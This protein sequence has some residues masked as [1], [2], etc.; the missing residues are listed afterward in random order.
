MHMLKQCVPDPL[1]GGREGSGDEARAKGPQ[2]YAH[3]RLYS[4]YNQLYLLSCLLLPLKRTTVEK[5]KHLAS[6]NLNG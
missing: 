1:L 5:W 3:F 4:H 6:Y 2:L